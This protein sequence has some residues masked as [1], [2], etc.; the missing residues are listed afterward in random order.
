MFRNIFYEILT[1]IQRA[2]INS[3]DIFLF[4]LEA[5]DKEIIIY[6]IKKYLYDKLGTLSSRAIY[7]FE[8]IYNTLSMEDSLVL[9]KN[10]EN[11]L[12]LSTFLPF[13]YATNEP[14][15]NKLS[16]IRAINLEEK[17]P[18]I[19]KILVNSIECKK[20]IPGRPYAD[21]VIIPYTFS[22]DDQKSV[23]LTKEFGDLFSS[24][25]DLNA[26]MEKYFSNNGKL[27]D[28][29]SP[30]ATFRPGTNINDLCEFSS[31]LTYEC[32]RLIGG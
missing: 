26:I 12:V 5:A 21:R 1:R 20:Y 14:F 25:A 27:I 28:N 23:E 9:H 2:G 8:K 29:I 6:D 18:E 22:Y 15:A 16:G 7:F 13:V 3:W 31:S 32:L 11:G 17:K 10:R 24:G 30:Y 4:F 19:S